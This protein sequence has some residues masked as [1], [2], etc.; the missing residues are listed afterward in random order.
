MAKTQT[1]ST[2][3]GL[4]IGLVLVAAAVFSVFFI[5]WSTEVAEPPPPVR[6]LKTMVIESPF[7]PSGRKYP[8]KVRASQQVD[9][10]FQVAGP[11][12]ELAVRSGDRVE[13]G[14]LL[15]R[16][17]PRDFINERDS[18]RAKVTETESIL[19]RVKDARA[20]QA[21]SERELIDAQSAFDIA[22]ADLQINEKAVEDTYLRAP[23]A[24]V[25]ANRFVDNFQN[26]RAKEP[27]VS[28][29][30]V[31]AVEI[32]VNV[33]E[34][35]VAS[36]KNARGRV[37]FV[38]SFDY[39]PGREFKVSPKEFATEAD[40]STQTYAVRFAMAAP[41]DVIILPGMTATVTEHRIQAEGT[42]DAG[43]TLPVEAVPV[44]GLG[45]YYVWLVISNS[46]GTVT[47]HRAD[48]EIGGMT[49]DDFLITSGIKKG[50]R[51][52]TAGVYFLQEGQQV[53]LIEPKA[54]DG[55]S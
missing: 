1:T 29:Q 39:L 2:L 52:A 22:T 51:V 47:V 53:R 21:A 49:Q 12:I 31:S 5:D 55:T 27:I 36:A 33:P 24:G 42:E 4:A 16:I 48:V 13:Q 37:Y 46:D 11:L 26:V 34:E 44:D 19:S 10:A 15:A 41:E 32:E 38:A 23:F 9:L 28:L 50:D 20:R 8:G 35:R 6:P 17:D 30:D 7:A 14:Q 43:Y 40:P 3:I 45:N 25:I 18:A 54:G